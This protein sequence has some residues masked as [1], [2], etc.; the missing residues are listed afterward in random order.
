MVAV[1]RLRPV[2]KLADAHARPSRQGT[3]RIAPGKLRQPLDSADDF[4]G[5]AGKKGGGI[6]RF[7]AHP[8]YLVKTVEF[9]V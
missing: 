6:G 4:C 3:G 2:G 8:L 9:V 5:N 1:A 7:G